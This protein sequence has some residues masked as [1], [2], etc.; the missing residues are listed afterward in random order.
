MPDGL[1]PGP[2][3][4]G[5][6][7]FTIPNHVAFADALA[8]G[9][10]A[11]AGGDP[12]A[13][14]RTTVLLPNRRAVA[15]VTD[16]FVRAMGEGGPAGLLLPRLTPVG[17]LGDDEGTAHPGAMRHP[18]R[19]AGQQHRTH[20]REHSLGTE[21]GQPMQAIGQHARLSHGSP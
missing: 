2:G 5:G 9:L 19:E 18:A 11:G 8:R 16:A 6:R 10:L 17:D 3:G 20:Q 12:L 14:S 21:G 1:P 7:L 4:R 15:A 13:L